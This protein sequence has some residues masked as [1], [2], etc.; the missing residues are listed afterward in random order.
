MGEHPGARRT[1]KW[2]AIGTVTLLVLV[3]AG[4]VAD[5][6]YL[7]GKVTTTCLSSCLPK[8]THRPTKAPQA[9]KA[10]NFVLIGSDSRAGA[11]GRGTGG[12]NIQGARSDTTI[13]LHISAHGSAA[14]LIS[15]P[16]DSWVQI[17]SC[18][19]KADG[20]TSTP[21]MNKFNAA[22]SIGSEYDNKYGPACTVHTIETLTGIRVDHFAVV[23]FS[24][25]RHMVDA[26]GG[27]RMC[28]AKPLDDPIVHDATGWHGTNLHLPSGLSVKIDGDQALALMRARYG[29]DGGGDLPRIR[30]QQQFVAA[31]IHKATSTGLL[32]NPISLQRFLSAAASSLTTDGFGL[33]TMRTLA[34]ALK[35]A[36]AESVHLTTVPNLLSAP[37]LPYGDVLWD[38]TKAPALWTAVRDDKSLPG[39]GHP[40]RA[41][42]SVTPTPKPT[43]GSDTSTFTANQPGCLS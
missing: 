4:V 10:E 36:G 5:Y 43:P 6:F 28:V 39:T 25:F 20:Q 9:L 15:I 13:V 17:P 3:V 18:V 23:D 12:A 27:V 30:R 21:E 31:M 38:P 14:T 19:V 32:V 16:R 22:F 24:G 34:A 1:L 35:K 29:L 11:N 33:G 42:H 2:V 37:G 40:S 41:P 8:G 26:L 7:N